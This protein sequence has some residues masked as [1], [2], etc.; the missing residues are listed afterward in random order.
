MIDKPTDVLVVSA[1]SDPHALAVMSEIA[2]RGFGSELLDLAQFPTQLSL[3]LNYRDKGRN[4]FCIERD[5]GGYLDLSQV[6]SIWWRRPQDFMFDERISNPTNRNFATGESITAFQGLFQCLGTKWINHPHRDSEAAHKSWQLQVAQEVDLQIP[7]TLITSNPKSAKEFWKAHGNDV[8]YKQFVAAKETWRETRRLKAGD[9][10]LAES[11][12]L[13]PVIFQGFVKGVADL[14]VIAIE[15]D[16]FAA[17]AE[18]DGAEYP[19]DVR[20]NLGIEYK[21]H[22]LPDA[23][24]TKILNLMQRLRL[25]YG[26]IDLRLTPEGEY[27]FFEINPSGQFLYIEQHTGLKIKAALAR[28]L[29]AECQE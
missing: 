26:A 12:S 4:S 14:R 17:A 19:E 21:P 27:I 8:V 15:N 20:M 25:T 22:N 13:A 10:F 23:V 1:V 29:T 24:R 5:I 7:P 28:A 11:I 16:L 18:M 3:S 9:E 6:K 2:Q